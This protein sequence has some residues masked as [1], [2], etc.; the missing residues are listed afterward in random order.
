MADALLPTDPLQGVLSATVL[1]W[2]EHHG[3][4][5]VRSRQSISRF[6]TAVRI[7]RSYSGARRMPASMWTTE[8]VTL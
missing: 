3:L 7:A 5:L 6:A 8:R 1:R 4:P 2:L